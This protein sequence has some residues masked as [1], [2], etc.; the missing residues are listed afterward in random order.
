MTVYGMRHCLIVAVALRIV[1]VLRDLL[2]AGRCWERRSPSGLLAI[3]F[4]LV[5]ST[6]GMALA[7]V[8]VG[9]GWAP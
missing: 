5:S 4:H 6:L 1:A 2:R 8:M 7:F 9:A 3:D